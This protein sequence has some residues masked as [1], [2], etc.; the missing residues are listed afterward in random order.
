MSDIVDVKTVVEI[1]AMQT[2]VQ[3]VK[4]KLKWDKDALKPER[5][6]SWS[7]KTTWDKIEKKV[8]KIF[9]QEIGERELF[10]IILSLVLEFSETYGPPYLYGGRGPHLQYR[11]EYVAAILIMKMALGVGNGKIIKKVEELGIDARISVKSSL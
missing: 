8:N 3:I 4:N 1:C 7:K 2:I 9:N 6:Q 5:K 10:E 11:P